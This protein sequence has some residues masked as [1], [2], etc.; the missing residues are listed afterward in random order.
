MY[1]NLLALGK[2]L[3]TFFVSENTDKELLL[4]WVK[5][6]PIQLISSSVMTVGGSK[7]LL[8]DHISVADM[9]NR[10]ILSEFNNLFLN[11]FIQ[12]MEKVSFSKFIK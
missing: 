10:Y 12:E 7:S 3:C 6:L 5:S 9:I 2:A 8:I 4:K 1:S 11:Y